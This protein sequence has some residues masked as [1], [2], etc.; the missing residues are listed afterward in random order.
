MYVLN[1]LWIR[2]L[3]WYT[4]H[5]AQCPAVVDMKPVYMCISSLHAYS[6]MKYIFTY[7]ERLLRMGHSNGAAVLQCVDMK[8]L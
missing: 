7:I 8:P 5:S 1:M 3:Q 2:A 4:V 6:Y